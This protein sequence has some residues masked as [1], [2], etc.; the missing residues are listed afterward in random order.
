MS[1]ITRISNGILSSGFGYGICPNSA[2]WGSAPVSVPLFG[3]AAGNFPAGFEVG[4]SGFGAGIQVLVRSV[5]V[6]QGAYPRIVWN[7]QTEITNA[8][9]TW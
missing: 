5:L 7:D 2:V 4:I 1:V 6:A 3:T 9:D 8:R